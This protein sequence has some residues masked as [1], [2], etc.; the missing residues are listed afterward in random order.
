[1][2]SGLPDATGPAANA[3]RWLLSGGQPG[4]TALVHG[5]EV[6][7]Y[8]ELRDRAGAW[9]A[10]LRS[11]G[12][13][14]G[15]RVGLLAENSPLLV[16]A[17]LGA[18]QAGLCAVPMPIAESEKMLSRIVAATGA[19]RI[20][21]SERLLPKLQPAAAG[22]GVG[23]LVQS[24][25]RPTQD[26]GTSAISATSEASAT[27]GTSATPLPP[28]EPRRD[29]A[30]IMWTSGST[31]APKGVMVAHGNI[32]ANTRDI[33]QYMDLRPEDR[34]MA[35]LPLSYCYGMSLVH[36]HL[37]V[38]GCVV[39]NN[40]FMFPEK[41]LDDLDRTQCTGLAGVP[42]TYQILLRKTHFAT[43]KFPS[44]QWLQQAGGKLPDRFLGELRQAMPQVK[45]YV[46]YG[47]T[48]AT[49]RLSYLPPERLDD[50]L[51][52]IGRGL[53]HTR[54]EVLKPDGTPVRPG[55]GEVGEIVASGDN[56]APGYWNDPCETA[57]FFRNGRLYTGDLARVDADGFLFL[58]DRT[59]D[60]I[61]AMGNRVSP[62]EVEEVL[63]EL[64]EVVEAA[65]VGVTDDLWG[66][67][68]KA[69]LVTT[70]PGCLSADAVRSH[71]V[72][73]L[74]NYKVP[75]YVEFLPRLPKTSHGKV[76][77]RRLAAVV[78]E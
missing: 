53:P 42:A 8:G 70:T 66:E 36:T 52:S 2:I 72:Q 22:R 71:C 57:R 25:D 77:K 51:G 73:R 12:L 67:A 13:V 46:M 15:D 37:A 27:S 68:V 5:D 65:V 6:V 62:K 40:R 4:A 33:I 58:V 34:V 19:R 45:L 64:P 9:T 20:V 11:E 24:P 54:L 43:R 10:R 26:A 76:D 59:R 50:K 49:A 18:M 35:V 31:G 29:L 41:V 14:A 30:A 48:E 44:L 55:S 39:L 28:P 60:F 74:P 75:Q 47:Q 56:I 7:T 3:G 63:A 1:M 32:F 61:K 23:L 17:Y 16:A 78:A 21:V 38:G 69:F